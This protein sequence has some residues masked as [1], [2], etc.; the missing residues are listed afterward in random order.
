[1]FSVCTACGSRNQPGSARC[2]ACGAVLDPHAGMGEDEEGHTRTQMQETFQW[3]WVWVSL[4]VNLGAQLVALVVLP[5]V[6]PAY[7]P[8]GLAGLLVSGGVWFACALMVSLISPGKT[9]IEPGVGALLAVGPTLS[10]LTWITPEG[11]QPSLYAYVVTAV[12]G[13]MSSFVGAFFGDQL[14]RRPS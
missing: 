1:M 3:K 8:Q 7:D 11:L 12:L 2:A 14:V 6:V 13:V 9:L 10:Y 4:A 5:R